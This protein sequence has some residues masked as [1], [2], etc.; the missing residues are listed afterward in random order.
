MVHLRDTGPYLLKVIAETASNLANMN[1]PNLCHWLATRTI[2]IEKKD[3]SGRPIGVGD[4]IRRV[5]LKAIE[6]KYRD[7]T[8][9]ACPLQYG[10]G[11]PFG[12]E[13]IIHAM[14][15]ICAVNQVQELIT[16]KKLIWSVAQVMDSIVYEGHPPSTAFT[17]EYQS[18][19]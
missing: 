18:C 3:G 7:K 12:S 15:E 6:R 10:N 9:Q 17:K 11:M 13:I 5:C 19:I 4:I 8:I 14:N 1:I 2:P 16:A